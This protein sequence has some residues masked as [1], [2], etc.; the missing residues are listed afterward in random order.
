MELTLRKETKNVS[1]SPVR[2]LS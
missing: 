1:V 2:R